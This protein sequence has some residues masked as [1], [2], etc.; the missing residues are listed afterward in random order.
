M[1]QYYYLR[2]VY[3]GLP[4]CCDLPSV[5]RL[6]P[7]QLLPFR[8]P[9]KMITGNTLSRLQLALIVAPSFILFGYNQAG[10]GGL[11]TEE[12]WV[13]TFPQIDTVNVTGALK[14]QHST[15]QGVVVAVFV[16]GALFGALSCSYTGN[17]FGRR[18]VICAGKLPYQKPT[19]FSLSNIYTRWYPH[20]DRFRPRSFSL[21]PCPIHRWACGAWQVSHPRCC[22]FPDMCFER[23]LGT[24]FSTFCHETIRYPISL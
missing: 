13:K 15:I 4:T 16:I 12:D 19:I 7:R 21:R 18:N 17:A 2:F 10:I 9:P 1:N 22:S 5:C 3:K 8:I 6:V 11:L 24:A 14:S 23:D 20:P